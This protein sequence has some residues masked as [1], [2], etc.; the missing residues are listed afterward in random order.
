MRV[1]LHLR[2]C[3]ATTMGRIMHRVPLL[4]LLR[5]YQ[6]LDAADAACR[7]RFVAFVEAHPDCFHREL[8]IGHVTG[9]AWIVDVAGRKVLLTHHRKLNLWLQPGGHADG[10]ADVAAV[11]LR[12]AQ[13]ETGL[14]G[15]QVEGATIF[16]V[17]IHRIPARETLAEH[18]HFDVRFVVQATAT[19]SFVVSDESHALAWVE[20]DAIER[21]STERS[22]LR[23]REKWRRRR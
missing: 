16:D 19:E 2:V 9:S 5:A 17:D 18:D 11:A 4:S 22:I 6:P 8:A 23:M 21:Y 7:N 12:E 20:I 1:G 3:S 10:D 15:L 14:T 13:E